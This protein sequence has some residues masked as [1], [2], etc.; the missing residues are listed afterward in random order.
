[1]LWL[2]W[3]D[4]FHLL[5]GCLA[6]VP[7]AAVWAWWKRRRQAEPDIEE[8]ALDLGEDLGPGIADRIREG[9]VGMLAGVVGVGVIAASSAALTG[10]PLY[11]FFY[12]TGCAELLAQVQT[13]KEG[14]ANAYALKLVEQ[15]LKRRASAGCVARLSEQRV[16]LL[17]SF[18]DGAS[19][20]AR[21]TQLRAALK[22]AENL[23]NRDLAALT[24][25]R[26]DLEQKQNQV[27][28]LQKSQL[29]LQDLGNALVVDIPDVL[30]G[31]NQRSLDPA[32]TEVIREIA[33]VILRT[34]GEN[35]IRVEGHTD[36]TG[37]PEFN[38]RLSRERADS[39][40]Q[41]LVAAGLNSNRITAEGF[42]ALRSVAGNDTAEGRARNRRVRVTI[43]K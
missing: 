3:L 39:V 41:S 26:L 14:G 1:M 19:V 7:S 25:A 4:G 20:A 28:R 21:E 9:L 17:L 32:A 16:R 22:E 15:R 2:G 27:D 38:E 37:S 18:A 8:A 33:S 12:D 36:N 13:L 35:L 10:T 5:A 11:G 6:V 31:P 43:P 23:G 42:G 30:F 24:R 34:A 29:V 40:K